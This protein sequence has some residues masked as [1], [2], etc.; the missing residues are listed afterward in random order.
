M[1]EKEKQH[2][3]IRL[4]DNVQLNRK[5]SLKGTRTSDSNVTAD[6]VHNWYATKTEER[7]P[8]CRDQLDGSD[9]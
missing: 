6:F 5:K 1:T 3:V 9:S 8:S 7:T 2:F 4:K